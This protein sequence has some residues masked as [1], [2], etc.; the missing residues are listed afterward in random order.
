MI[1][2]EQFFLEQLEVWETA[3][4]N[5]DSLKDIKSKG[6]DFGHFHIK[7]QYNPERIQSSEASTDKKS[8]IQRPC[9]LCKAN[10]PEHQKEID[11]LLRYNIL[12]NP[13]PIFNRHLTISDRD[14]VPQL[15]KYRIK[16][17]LYLA[18]DLPEF[19]ILYNGPASGASA[20]DHFHFQAGNKNFLPIEQDIKYYPYKENLKKEEKGILYRMKHYL[21]E[22]FIFESK[23]IDWLLKEFALFYSTLQEIQYNENE[24]MFNLICKKEKSDWQLIVF[25]RKKHRPWQ[26]FEKEENKILLSPGVVDFG[27]VLILPR[28]ED[29][30][31]LNKNIIRNIYS[32]LTLNIDET[33]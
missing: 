27:G 14:H 4:R 15:I 32:Q 11:Y 18:N 6:F 26:Y 12:I 21:R 31:K 24:P 29:Y 5:Y 28:K 16:D 1:N 2:I 9:F 19:T 8:L 10:R 22:C 25:P 23:D 7:I 30:E 20:P 17:M 33:T 3:S 13:Y